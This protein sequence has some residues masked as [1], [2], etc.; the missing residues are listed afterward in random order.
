M[1]LRGKRTPRVE[2]GE[3][4]CDALRL[5]GREREEFLDVMGLAA[6]PPRVAALVAK[7]EQRLKQRN[8]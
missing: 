6:S 2:R 3:E 8:D 4:W 5:S 7:L 1:I